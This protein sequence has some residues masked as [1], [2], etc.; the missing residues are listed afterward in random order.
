MSPERRAEL[1]AELDR[2]NEA[3]TASEV[4]EQKLRDRKQEVAREILVGSILPPLHWAVQEDGTTLV[5]DERVG[6]DVLVLFGARFHHE[7]FQLTGFGEKHPD[8]VAHELLAWL[9]EKKLLAF[10]AGDDPSLF[11]LFQAE[12]QRAFPEELFVDEKN[13]VWA[14]V[15]DTRLTVYCLD[16]DR[17]LAFVEEH[18]LDV[19]WDGAAEVIAAA[20]ERAAK[21][22]ARALEVQTR[23]ARFLRPKVQDDD[24]CA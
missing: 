5:A 11:A 1:D 12:T 18:G 3:L 23:L 9:R 19:R 10:D 7:S 14:Q 2:L 4:E 17:L 21:E 20:K 24:D 6:I 13:L 16:T 8:R 15:D 22:A